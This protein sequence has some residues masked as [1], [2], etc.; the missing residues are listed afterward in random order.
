MPLSAAQILGLV[1]G[2][3]TEQVLQS[4]L[5]TIAGHPGPSGVQNYHAEHY[6]RDG[7]DSLKISSNALALGPHA[8]LVPAHSVQMITHANTPPLGQIPG[9]LLDG[10]GPDLMLTGMLNG[11]SFVMKANANRT[12]VRCAHLQP[13]L[14][15]GQGSALNVHCINGAAF[16]G[17][18]GP[19]LVYGRNSYPDGAGLSRS[20]TV[21][22]VRRAGAWEI[23]AQIFDA[24]AFTVVSATR[25]L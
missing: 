9:Y 15:A 21:L 6:P 3:T 11:C 2:P 12:A 1:S 16:V 22:G 20:S 13:Q 19:V 14:G 10:N 8:V 23:Y 25:I 4:I 24:A 5:I 18:A 7:R 17:D